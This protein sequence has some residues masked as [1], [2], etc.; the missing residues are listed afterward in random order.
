MQRGFKAQDAV[1]RKLK[2]GQGQYFKLFKSGWQLSTDQND[3]AC[4][5]AFLDHFGVFYLGCTRHKLVYSLS[6]KYVTLV[7]EFE[8]IN[9]GTQNQFL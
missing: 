2:L 4:V 5:H 7:F 1:C 3:V 8:V 9:Y 6:I